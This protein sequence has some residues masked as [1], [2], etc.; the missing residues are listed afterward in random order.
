M[1][2]YTRS[3]KMFKFIIYISNVKLNIFS[4][5]KCSM[6]KTNELSWPNSVDSVRFE[7]FGRVLKILSEMSDAPK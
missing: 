1:P 7:G 3:L 6:Y 5:Y 4:L 2:E